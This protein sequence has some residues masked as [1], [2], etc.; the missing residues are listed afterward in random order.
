MVVLVKQGWYVEYLKKSKKKE[1]VVVSARCSWVFP[2]WQGS[3]SP[4]TPRTA[5]KPSPQG[6]IVA[7]L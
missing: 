5:Q 7:G 2:G 6:S 1:F 3:V 4:V